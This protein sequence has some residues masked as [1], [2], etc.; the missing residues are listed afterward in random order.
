MMSIWILTLFFAII[1]VLSTQ[2]GHANIFQTFTLQELSNDIRFFLIQWVLTLAI[3]LWR[4]GTPLGLQLPKWEFTW[5][6][7]G[8]FSH[9]LPHLKEHKMWFP[10][11][12]LGPHLRKPK[13]RVATISKWVGTTMT[14]FIKVWKLFMMIG[15]STWCQMWQRKRWETSLCMCA[16]LFKA[17][18]A[19]RFQKNYGI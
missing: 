13:A 12:T 3:A 4:F 9:I 16:S 10:G 15:L 2:M 6:C 7:G 18:V 14:M 5:K 1:C 11:F 8:S 19:T 17:I